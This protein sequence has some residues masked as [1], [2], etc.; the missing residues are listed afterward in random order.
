M[1]GSVRIGEGRKQKVKRKMN[2]EKYIF[3]NIDNR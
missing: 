3:W 1:E 2:P